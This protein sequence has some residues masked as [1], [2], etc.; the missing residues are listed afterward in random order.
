MDFINVYY[1]K[2]FLKIVYLLFVKNIKI[3]LSKL[4]IHILLK[5]FIST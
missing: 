5:M 1:L 2:I 4:Q 3:Y